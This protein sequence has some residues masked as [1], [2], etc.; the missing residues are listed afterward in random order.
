MDTQAFC[1]QCGTELKSGTR[2]CGGCGT[3]IDG[4]GEARLQ[5]LLPQPTPSD[6]VYLFGESFVDRDNWRSDGLALEASGVKVQKKPLARTMI[7]AAIA[8]LIK[9]GW[10]ELAVAKRG[11]LIFQQQVPVLRRLSAQPYDAGGLEA[12]LLQKLDSRGDW[13]NDVTRVVS[14]LAGTDQMD[15]WGNV[16]KF[17]REHLIETGCLRAEANPAARGLGKLLHAAYRVEP[18]QGRIG[19]VA[20]RIGWVQGLLQEA[21]ARDVRLWEWATKQVDKALKACEAKRDDDND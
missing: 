16:T 9:E 10:I 6:L 15:P 5:L 8:S 14:L 12:A 20:P 18:D 2:F 21:R 19:E 3:S 11:W 13:L 4:R 1:N 17:A 7:L